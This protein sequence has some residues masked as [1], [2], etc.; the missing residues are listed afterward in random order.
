MEEFSLESWSASLH[1]PNPRGGERTSTGMRTQTFLLVHFSIC[2][3]MSLYMVLHACLAQPAS[4]RAFTVMK[5][6]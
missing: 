5:Q 2:A 6:V 1:T 4:I 3:D